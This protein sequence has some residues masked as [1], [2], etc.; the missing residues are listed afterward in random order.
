MT[1]VPPVVLCGPRVLGQ[2]VTGAAA[3]ALQSPRVRVLSLAA[4]ARGVG[5]REPR[6][7]SQQL[8]ELRLADP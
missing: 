5:L 4:C 2:P 3:V 6:S 7:G 1:L 8:L